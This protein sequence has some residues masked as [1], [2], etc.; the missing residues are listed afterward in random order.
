M[1][2]YS[3][4]AVKQLDPEKLSDYPGR[5]VYSLKKREGGAGEGNEFLLTPISALRAGEKRPELK[6]GRLELQSY[7]LEHREAVKLGVPVAE[8]EVSSQ[9]KVEFHF[10]HGVSASISNA[11]I[12]WERVLPVIVAIQARAQRSN[13]I[14]DA[15]GV[16][17]DVATLHASSAVL[18]GIDIK[19]ATVGLGWSL[20]GQ[21]YASRNHKQEEIKV[22]VNV[23]LVPEEL[24][25]VMVDYFKQNGTKGL[26]PDQADRLSSPATPPAQSKTVARKPTEEV[27]WDDRVTSKNIDKTAWQGKVTPAKI[28]ALADQLG[29]N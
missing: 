1:A 28:T 16:I 29:K 19:A 11:Q 14:I 20:G 5:V 6:P 23:T 2:A 24:A 26:P 8:A 12:D 3:Y 18:Q 27:V 13:M 22:G 17:E 15:I 25:A 4:V 10:F 9:R 7:L 21:F